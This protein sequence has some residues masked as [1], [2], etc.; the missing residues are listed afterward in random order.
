MPKCTCNWNG[1]IARVKALVEPPNLILRGA[2]RHRIPFTQM[3]GVKADCEWLRFNLKEDRIA[4]ELG[5]ALATKWVDYLTAPPQTLAK[6]LGITA[7]NAVRMIRDADDEALQQA[8]VTARSSAAPADLILARVNTPQE[9]SRTL[10]TAA[11]QL[12]RSVPIWLIY[13]KGKGQALTEDEVRDTALATGIV[14]TKVAAVSPR[15]TA[16][17]FVKRRLSMGRR[18]S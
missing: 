10:K 14:D 6:K 17:R 5:S 9:L 11:D 18:D 3:H 2:L 8:L 1:T 7:D 15:L 16:L 4:L 13:R 12:D